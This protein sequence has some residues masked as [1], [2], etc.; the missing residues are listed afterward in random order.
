MEVRLLQD[1]TR[2][3]HP[4]WTYISL[5]RHYARGCTAGKEQSLLDRIAESEYA[6]RT[7]PFSKVSDLIRCLDILPDLV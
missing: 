3:P 2:I 7:Q 6:Y 1:Y 4:P 5:G